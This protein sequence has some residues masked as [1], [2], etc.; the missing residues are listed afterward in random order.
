MQNDK[1]FQDRLDAYIE[2]QNPI[3]HIPVDL[4][5]KAFKREALAVG[6]PRPLVNKLVRAYKKRSWMEYRGLARYR[7]SYPAHGS[8]GKKI[9]VKY[10]KSESEVKVTWHK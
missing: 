6:L 9:E 3:Y 2:W 8:I 7:G 10:V 4:G 1:N 5:I